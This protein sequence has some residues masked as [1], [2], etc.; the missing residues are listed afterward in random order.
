[1]NKKQYLLSIMFLLMPL[2][3]LAQWNSITNLP[4]IYIETFNH[5]PINSKDNYIYANIYMM[6][7]EGHLQEY[8]SVEIRGRG[9]STWNMAKKPYK[10]KFKEKE[11]FLGQGYAKA[12]KWTLLANA[13]DKTL[14]RN[15]LTSALGQFTSLKFNP[16]AKFVDVVLN[17]EYLGTYQISDQV[18]VR[19][20]RVNIVEQDVPLAENA[21]ISGGYL[22][23]VDGFRDGNCFTTAYYSTPIRIHS[24]EDE[25]IVD[26]QNRYIRNYVNMF[27]QRLR[28]SQFADPVKGYRH[29]VDSMSLVDWYLCTE[30]SANIDGFYSTY[31]YKEQADSLLYFGPL[32]DYDIAYDNDWRIWSEQGLSTTTYS[33]MADIAYS[34]SKQWVNRMWEDPWFA[35]RVYTRYKQLLDNGLV[36]YMQHKVDSL[37]RVLQKSQ[38]KNYERWGIQRRMYHELVLYSSYDQYV[39]DLKQFIYEHC[40]FLEETFANKKPIEPTPPFAPANYYYHLQNVRS[41]K[42][43]DLSATSVCQYSNQQDRKSQDWIIRKVGEHFQIINRTNNLALNDPTVGACTPTTNVGTQLDV[44][45]PDENSERQLWE[46][47]PQGTDGY[48]NL[49]NVYTQHIANLE[50]G[51]S[52]DFARIL[53]YTNDS[54]NGES[55]NRLWYVVPNGALPEEITG[56]HDV[57]PDEYALAYDPMTQELHFASATPERL[58]HFNA[59]VYS[60][61]GQ[62]VGTFRADQRY[63]MA[64]QPRGIYVVTWKCGGRQRSIKFQIANN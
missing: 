54:R 49:M 35:K 26:K 12:K 11:K 13:A 36:D 53:S 37:A 27:E 5:A 42:A 4:A 38:A 50:G 7:D 43:M 9:N 21:D 52:N 32:W 1:M 61:N 51:S 25:D 30:I 8:D 33:L 40:D 2:C 16:A 57:E 62:L 60:A 58:Q 44:V 47:I 39:E 22:L 31:F 29:V 45:T 34:G 56:I 28:S 48:Y 20:H 19:A 63:S 15:A 24:P 6:N 64:G 3:A 18:E 17:G 46:L 14:M 55:L 10:I 59:N 23:E 41:R